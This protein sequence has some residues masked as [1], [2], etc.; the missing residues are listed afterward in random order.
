MDIVKAV[1]SVSE[2]KCGFKV[3]ELKNTQCIMTIPMAMSN[4][5]NILIEF[6]SENGGCITFTISF[7]KLGMSKSRFDATIVKKL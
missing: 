6:A 1:E 5:T 2:L 3:I 4:D 7:E